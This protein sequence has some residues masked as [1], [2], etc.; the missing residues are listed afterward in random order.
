MGDPETA[1]A[2]PIA[3]VFVLGGLLETLELVS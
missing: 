1:A 2:T 3:A